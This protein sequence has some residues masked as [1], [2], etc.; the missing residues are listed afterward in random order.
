MARALGKDYLR[1]MV[2]TAGLGVAGVIAEHAA[3]ATVGRLPFVGGVLALAVAAYFPIVNARIL[4]LLVHVR[5][6][7]LDLGQRSDYLEPLLPGAVPQGGSVELE[8]APRRPRAEDGALR[9]GPP[10]VARSVPIRGEPGPE[11]EPL[12]TTV[13]VDGAPAPLE[14]DA[15]DPWVAP[16]LSPLGAIQS[17]VSAGDLRQAYAL[18]RESAGR[19]EGLGA[20]ELFQLARGAAQA[21]DHPV[22]A[23]ALTSAAAFHDDPVAPDVLLVLGRVYRTRLG[24]PAE[25]RQTF[26]ALI[27]RYPE[28]GAARQAREEL[29]QR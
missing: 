12:L 1:A 21:G 13:A 26:E 23:W 16:P 5:G 9:N 27:A 24:K 28:S 19:I 20:G 25:A 6:D 10:P 4:G 7:D 18:Y 29:A 8:P 17:A 2:T 11:D 14:P 15:G 3:A 22:A